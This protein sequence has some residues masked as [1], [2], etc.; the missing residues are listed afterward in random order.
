MTTALIFG[1]GGIGAAVATAVAAEGHR[2]VLVSRTDT[3]AA[4]L[5][6]EGRVADMSNPNE[7]AELCLWAAREVG[8]IELM[9]CALGAMNGERLDRIT[10]DQTSR[11]MADNFT[12]THLA[13]TQATP[14]LSPT[15]HRFVCGAY[16]ERLALPGL[17]AYAAAKAAVDAWARVLIKEERG[18]KTTLLRLPAVDTS[19][20]RTA[21]FP[22]PKGAVPPSRVAEV[23]MSHWRDGTVGVVDVS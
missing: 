8:P 6:V 10:P 7:V 11:V 17:G 23:V 14:L 12:S 21:P 1:A 9:V 18:I 20:W 13:V 15:A 5:G 16:L 3:V 4:R 2:V 19:L 22:L